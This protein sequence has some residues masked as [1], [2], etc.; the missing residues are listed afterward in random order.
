MNIQRLSWRNILERPL[1]TFMSLLLL[2]LGVSIISLL[3]ILNTQL[4]QTFKKNIKGIDMVVGA[5]GSPLQLILASVYHIDNPTGNIP[6]HEAEELAAHP[7]IKEAIKMAY[8][9][10]YVG[11]RILGTEKNYIDHYGGK[12]AIGNFFTKKYE[13]VLGAKTAKILDLKVG[14]EFFGNH[15]SSE[16][17][18]QHTDNA[19]K[20]VGIL[21]PSETVLDN[22]ILTQIESVWGIH[23]H[24][25]EGEEHEE[26]HT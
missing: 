26:G 14:D 18:E 24:E 2:T 9:D 12:L 10:N 7:L 8:G 13:V 5:K 6:L 11:Y 21:E 16:N 4:D 19:Y 3:L 1:S 17:G 15:G 22:L 20:V 23:D 25:E